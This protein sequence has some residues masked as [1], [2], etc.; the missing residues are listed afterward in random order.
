MKKIIAL[1][2][3]SISVC[4]SF[5]TANYFVNL[6][7]RDYQGWS[8]F[9]HANGYLFVK[10]ILATVVWGG[11][12]S[13]IFFL[14]KKESKKDEDETL[15]ESIFDDMHLWA[16]SSFGL[17]GVVLI[18]LLLWVNDDITKWIIS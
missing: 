17:V 18:P 1:V 11:I 13:L 8:E 10:M 9:D 12:V 15:I 7:A 16:I 14:I 4:A 5:M 6:T 3:V 2:I